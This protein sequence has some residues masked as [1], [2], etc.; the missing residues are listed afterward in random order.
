MNET[1]KDIMTLK[2]FAK[3]IQVH[4]NTVRRMIKS[5]QLA[6]FKVGSGKNSS[7]RIAKSE[8]LRLS[9]MNF[10]LHNTMDKEIK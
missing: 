3:Y 1:E 10:N 5:G 8:T 4:T 2:E 7:Y 6:A 9:M